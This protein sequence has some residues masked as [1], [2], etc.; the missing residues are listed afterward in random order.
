L[1]FLLERIA[2][3]T[4]GFS[5]A[6]LKNLVNEATLLAGREHKPRV[7]AEDFDRAW[8]KILLRSQRDE[9]MTDDEKKIAA[10]HEAGHAL[11]VK[12]LPE[13]D[14]LQKVTIIPTVGPWGR[15]SSFPRRIATTSLASI[16]SIA[17]P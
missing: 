5:G 17:S 3:R 9:P 14:P 15:P 16:S 4:V 6:D 10:Y 12:V 7:D 11:L 1:G 2:A 13:T 8:D